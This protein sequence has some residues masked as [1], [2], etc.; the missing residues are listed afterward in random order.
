MTRL[1]ITLEDVQLF[2]WLL[3][4]RVLSIDQVRR[5]R[6][7]HADGRLTAMRNVRKRLSRLR[8]SGY[9]EAEGSD[10]TTLVRTKVYRLGQKALAPLRTHHGI[11]QRA[12]YRSPGRSA[13]LQ[14]D[15]LVSETAI[16]ITESLRNRSVITPPLAPLGMSFY[17]TRIVGNAGERR[18]V[19]RYVSQEDILIASEPRP[20]RIRPDLVFALADGEFSQ[21]YFLELDRGFESAGQIA[22]KQL[23]YHHFA[24]VQDGEKGEGS[25]MRWQRYLP[26]AR[27]F[28]VLFVTTSDR[29]VEGLRRKLHSV[30]GCERM[31]FT[32]IG[33]LQQQDPVYDPIWVTWDG[34]RRSLMK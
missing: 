15:L 19:E 3:Q 8:A 22:G 16:R 10:A 7:C 26:D 14:H 6:Y 2:W 20:L 25:R 32:T 5:L 1:V 4:L 9:L 23:A 30:V 21:L 31:A 33:R 24:R 17:T 11:E 12:L 29:R 34:S 18:H 28:R 27:A 13:Q